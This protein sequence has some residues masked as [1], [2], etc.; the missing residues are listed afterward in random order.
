MVFFLFAIRVLLHLMLIIFRFRSPSI[1][2]ALKV[3]T[4]L[5]PNATPVHLA[6]TVTAQQVDI[7]PTIASIA[8][9]SFL[10]EGSPNMLKDKKPSQIEAHA[11]P[12]SITEDSDSK[13]SHSRLK[14]HSTVSRLLVRLKQPLRRTESAPAVV[15]HRHPHCA[16]LRAM[17]TELRDDG[18][19][20]FT[21]IP[22]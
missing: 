13:R 9:F 22:W 21:R 19:D 3:H 20:D 6:R 1:T 5:R 11:E 15:L 17:Q 8:S 4:L 7:M 2:Q 12:R 14:P 18:V 10:H 16:D